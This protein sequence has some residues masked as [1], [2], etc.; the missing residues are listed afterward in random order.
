MEENPNVK[1]S[2]VVE[3]KGTVQ[4]GRGSTLT[5]F[6]KMKRKTNDSIFRDITTC[7]PSKVNRRFGV[8]FRLHLQG[9]SV[10]QTKKLAA[11]FMC[12]NLKSYKKKCL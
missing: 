6:G 10:S 5:N 12:E 3:P 4:Q 2:I 11:C 8:T 9:L 1:E 7:R